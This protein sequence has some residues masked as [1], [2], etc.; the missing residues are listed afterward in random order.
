VAPPESVLSPEGLLSAFHKWR[1]HLKDFG[2]TFSLHER[3]EV[4]A[5]LTGG[6]HQGVSYNGL[7]ISKLDVDLDKLVGWSGAEFFASAF[8]IH[9]HGP[10]RSLVGN[11]Q[12]VSNIEA[13]PSLKL[14]DLWLDQSL[15]DKTLSIRLGQE[16]TND[17]MM[18][19]TY[20]GLFLNSS[21]GFP[22]MPAAVL[23]SGGPNYPMATPFVRAQL[24]PNDT[25]TIIG[26][27]YNGDPAPPGT[28]DPQ[29]RDRNGTAFRLDDHALAFGEVWYSPDPS[30]SAALPTTYKLGAWYSSSPFADQRFDTA[31]GLLAN[32]AG[33]GLALTH[34]GDW[35]FYGIIDQK[36]WERPDAK[37]Q[38]IGVFL[39]VMG[40][41]SDRNLSN[42]FV[43]GGMNFLAPF[44]ERPDDVFGVAVTY[45]GISPAA[46]N[47]SR[48]LVSFGRAT[49]SFAS[50]ETI[51]EATY[52]APV[53]NWLTLQPDV[54]FVFNPGAGVPGNF[55][56][57]PLSDAVVIG[58]RATFKL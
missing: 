28:G 14:Y 18:T 41:P 10:S 57:A 31:G 17:E 40:G 32:P 4:W 16:G 47:F 53:T 51:L 7:T 46:R 26:A 8:D 5:N 25:V 37:E 24:K 20:G 2:I 3:S 54:Q 43:E 39:Q 6:G 44:T 21:F 15:F 19:T 27:V 42:F 50:N 36:V 12:L 11:L 34:S 9:G 23:P 29:I 45:L 48:D 55:G 35:A 38:G 58:I 1:A 52:T 30:A 22:G 13:T 49:S 56:R 33:S